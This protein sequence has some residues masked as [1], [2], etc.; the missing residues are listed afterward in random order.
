MVP[1]VLLVLLVAA[2]TGHRPVTTATDIILAAAAAAGVRQVGFLQHPSS[3]W[4]S[5]VPPPVTES[6]TPESHPRARHS[7]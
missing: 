7:T 3:S 1:V 2:E 4:V 5:H 6:L